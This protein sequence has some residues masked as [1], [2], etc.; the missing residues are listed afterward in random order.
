MQYEKMD[1][2]YPRIPTSYYEMIE[3][4]LK[5]FDKLESTEDPGYD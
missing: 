4:L 3:K 5:Y 2:D 1:V